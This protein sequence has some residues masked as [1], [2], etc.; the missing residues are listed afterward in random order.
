MTEMFERV[1]EEVMDELNLNA[2]YEL[3]DSE[4]FSIVENRIAEKLGI[5]DPYENEEF[6]NWENEM[7]ND[8]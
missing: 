1:F 5:T 2:W 8:L 6:C 7:Y 4:K 3:Y